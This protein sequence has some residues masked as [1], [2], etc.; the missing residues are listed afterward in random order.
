[1]CVGCVGGCGGG[2]LGAPL[3]CLPHSTAGGDL[4][5]C[6]HGA[7]AGPATQ[8][9]AARRDPPDFIGR[10][11]PGTPKPGKR[12]KNPPGRYQARDAGR[13]S[14][15]T[16]YTTRQTGARLAQVHMD[17]LAVPERVSWSVTLPPWGWV[18]SE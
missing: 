15:D 4:G 2:G 8:R 11:P 17:D 7:S 18:R 13:V 10:A 9:D 14:I 6:P 3:A 5:P 1:M 12:K 16:P